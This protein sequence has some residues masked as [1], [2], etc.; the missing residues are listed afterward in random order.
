MKIEL[1]AIQIVS[2]SEKRVE[3]TI[4]LGDNAQ[5]ALGLSAII[6]QL[7]MV[8]NAKGARH[9][10]AKGQ[11]AISKSLQM[12]Q[13]RIVPGQYLTSVA[14]HHFSDAEHAQWRAQVF[15]HTDGVRPDSSNLVAEVTQRFQ[16]VGLGANEDGMVVA[17]SQAST[18]EENDAPNLSELP[19]SV[20]GKK[21]DGVADRRRLQIFEGACE[22]ISKKGWAN[23]SIRDITQ[24][25]KIT[26]PT[27]YQYI[28][29]KEDILYL[30]TSM[31]MEEILEY[32]QKRVDDDK[33]PI[34]SLTD[35]VM[36]YFQYIDKNRRY[37]NLLYSETRSLNEENRE[38]IF[39]LE[40]KFVQLWEAILIKGNQSGVFAIKNTDLAANLIYFLCTSWSLRHWNI[41]K[42]PES[43]VREHILHMVLHGISQASAAPQQ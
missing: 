16:Y 30:V 12:E 39:Y 34:D 19:A 11:H 36:A 23:A 25:A 33:A 26:I 32:F 17:S 2:D 20:T 31:C 18:P 13:F 4:R 6:T 38:R 35:A 22:V 15:C 40:K 43:E 3:A 21:T 9:L 42:Y 14:K 1:P 10:A 7:G 37:I 5:Q 28:S 29:G 24:A 41:G 8:A 27:M